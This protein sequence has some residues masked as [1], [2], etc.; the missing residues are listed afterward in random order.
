MRIR[1]FLLAALAGTLSSGFAA[2]PER[3]GEAVQ[4]AIGV[5]EPM[6]SHPVGDCGFSGRVDPDG[7]QRRRAVSQATQL[8]AASHPARETVSGA[9]PAAAS[10][11]DAP[12]G[13]ALLHIPRV[14][15]VDD[16]IF[17]KMEA[18]NVPSAP[19]SSDAE[20]LRRVSLD[21]VGRIPDAATLQAFLHN[22][23][24]DKRDRMI[25]SLLASNEFVDRWAFFFDDLFKVTAVAA[26]GRLFVPGRNQYHA[27]FVDAVRSHKPYD[28][29][30]R[31]LIA[32]TGDTGQAGAANFPVRNVQANG[33]AQDTYD[34]LAATSGMT[35]LGT[36]AFFCA[37]CHNGA[38]HMDLINLWGSTFRRQDFWGM[39]AFF[40]RTTIR[41][42][43]DQAANYTFLVGE[44]PAG[45][46]QLN[47]TT[48]NKT[49]RVACTATVTT[50]CWTTDPL[51]LKSI[52]PRYYRNGETPMSGEGNRQAFARLVTSDPQF[53]RA[54]ANYVFKEL[55]TV[56]I[57]EPADGF[58][59]ARQDPANPPPGTWT[60]QPTHP[61][62]L[63]KLGQD[64][65]ANGYD[66]RSLL[67]TL[68]RSS[69]YQLSSYYP[70]TWSATYAPYFARHYVRRLPGEMLVDAITRATGVPLSL[71]VS[72]Y[73]NPVGWAVQLPDTAEPLARGAGGAVR[74]FL[75]TFLRGDR[76][77]DARS[78][79]GSISQAL[80]SLNDATVVTSRVKSTAAGSTVQKALAGNST[81]D[82]IVTSLYLASLSR[83]PS[84]AE[85]QTALALFANLKPGQTKASV[86]EDLQWTL[87]NKLDF[88]F[89]Y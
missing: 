1:P 61:N 39:S 4:E 49:P 18:D 16:E 80:S 40:S 20:F 42:Q 74:A 10:V 58:D 37:S 34:N 35:L 84:P 48:G 38:G 50:G 7:A 68:A 65:T 52:A 13:P 24:P 15:Y 59:F 71:T 36:N 41:R 5:T 63:V 14:N 44:A 79:Q 53:A 89:K 77:Q 27:Y 23:A 66:L 25:D 46:Y 69:A 56:G 21:L 17:G 55:F 73:T 67:R 12:D 43:G 11:P 86:A 3:D 72:G 64:F 47:T 33:P 82:S 32:A 78:Y 31:E 29:M 76:D 83:Y 57:V 2:P 85:R 6:A 9:S 22:P 88:V 62:L 54:F 8:F 30:V 28:Q 19:L 70:G 26:N 60:I 45:T 75:D 51:G 87:F 81:P